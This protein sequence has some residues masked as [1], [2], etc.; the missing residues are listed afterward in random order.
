MTEAFFSDKNFCGWQKY[1]SVTETVFLWQKCVSLTETWTDISF[2]ERNLFSKDFFVPWEICDGKKIVFVTPIFLKGKFVS[3]KEVCFFEGIFFVC[4]INLFLWQKNVCPK[5]PVLGILH[6][7][8]KEKFPWQIGVLVILE[9][10]R[11]QLCGALLLPS[12][13]NCPPTK[14]LWG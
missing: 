10:P 13:S 5:H 2:C 12:H 1:V 3:V 8:S 6:V 9:F 4:Y 7:I 14:L 11:L